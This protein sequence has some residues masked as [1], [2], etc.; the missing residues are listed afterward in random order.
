MKAQNVSQF[1]TANNCPDCDSETSVVKLG[2]EPAREVCG[3]FGCSWDGE[4][5]E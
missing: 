5:L 1:S 2:A 3:K 4:T